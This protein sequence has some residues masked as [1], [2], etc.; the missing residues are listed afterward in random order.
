MDKPRSKQGLGVFIFYLGITF[1][2]LTG[3]SSQVSNQTLFLP[4]TTVILPDS[5][6]IDETATTEGL[7]RIG[8]STPTI[9]N[10]CI[11]NLLYIED[12]TFPDGTIVKA[13]IPIKKQWRVENNGSCNWNSRYLLRWVSG[14]D[15]GGEPEIAL[16]P[17]K[18]G[19]KAIIQIDI[20]AP[21]QPGTYTATWNAFDPNGQPFGDLLTTQIVVIP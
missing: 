6:L 1:L 10:N 16:Y 4:P 12:L 21:N 14:D 9:N 15:L 19:S 3:C 13:G 11:N 18:A 7:P 20:I 8:S 17:A 2:L 5:S